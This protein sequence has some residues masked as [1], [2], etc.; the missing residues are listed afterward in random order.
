MNGPITAPQLK[1]IL[2]DRLLVSGTHLSNGHWL[3]L[4][5]RLAEPLRTGSVATLEAVLGVQAATLTPA[6]VQGVLADAHP[7]AYERTCLVCVSWHKPK[8]KKGGA[9][10]AETVLFRSPKGHQVWVARDYAVTLDLW[11]LYGHATDGFAALRDTVASIAAT[12]AVMPVNAGSKQDPIRHVVP[13]VP[14]PEAPADQEV[15][16]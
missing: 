6:M 1:R 12:V 2:G 10:P 14:L 4:R 7:V 3:V 11:T 8:G 9:Q 15:A 13:P 5:E 16:S